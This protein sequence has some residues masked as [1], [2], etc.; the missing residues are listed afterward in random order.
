MLEVK[1]REPGPPAH[2]VSVC[3]KK[4][5]GGVTEPRATAH[6]LL[7]GARYSRSMNNLPHG[8]RQPWSRGQKGVIGNQGAPHLNFL[9]SVAQSP[10]PS[11]EQAALRLEAH[12]ADGEAP[13]LAWGVEGGPREGGGWSRFLCPN[14]SSFIL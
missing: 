11:A 12:A 3:D 1:I 4:C 2:A 14:P 9:A 13:Q 10:K 5:P 7:D 6:I 8:T